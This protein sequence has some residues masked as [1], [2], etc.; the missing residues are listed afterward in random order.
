MHYGIRSRGL[1]FGTSA[2]VGPCLSDA[3]RS[4][5]HPSTSVPP[6]NYWQVTRVTKPP[7]AGAEA[8]P[9][10]G[11]PAVP[12][13]G[14]WWHGCTP[15]VRVRR[16]SSGRGRRGLGPSLGRCRSDDYSAGTSPH[17]EPPGAPN[18]SSRPGARRRSRGRLSS[19][20][21]GGRSAS[22]PPSRR[23]RRSTSADSTSTAPHSPCRAGFSADRAGIPGTESR[24]F[25]PRTLRC[26]GRT[27]RSR[28]TVP[29]ENHV[30]EE[31]LDCGIRAPP[32]PE[33]REAA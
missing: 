24:L 15:G 1:L 21:C 28:P 32:D 2:R 31:D 13:G 29:E 12:D 19:P 8:K 11:R 30:G 20:A 22:R 4:P 27:Q 10:P 14:R 17:H 26:R 16:A 9:A 5:G 3:G 33:D 7:T 25:G 18:A 6:V 23:T